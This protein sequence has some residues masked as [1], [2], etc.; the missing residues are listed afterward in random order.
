M[1]TL[2]LSLLVFS[3][4]AA[5]AAARGDDV[6]WGRLPGV[7]GA[8]A[9]PG[10]K[11]RAVAL[12]RAENCYH[13]CPDTVYACVTKAAPAPTALRMAGIILRLLIDGKTPEEVSAELKNRAKSAHPFKKATIDLEGMPRLGPP[14]AR[15]TVVIFA[16][17]DCPYCRLVSSRLKE[18]KAAMGDDVSIVFKLFPVKAHGSKAVATSKAG[19]AAHLGGC[20][21]ALHDEMYAN[22]DDHDPE[23]VTRMAA[24][25]GCGLPDFEDARGARS[26]TDAVRALKREGVKLGV[27]STPTI[28]VNN[29]RYHGLKT[30]AELR[31]RLE[32]ELDLTRH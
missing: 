1:R 3:L 7:D 21:W 4:L 29:K 15:V 17:F 22:F 26:T 11:D 18:M 2:I 14:D 16:D 30:A 24:K 31:D 23:D 19:W 13:E 28:F 10:V 12:M 32:E 20:F 9:D 27:K 8:N 25:A 6:P 5:P